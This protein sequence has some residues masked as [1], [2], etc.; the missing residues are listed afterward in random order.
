MEFTF[1]ERAVLDRF[2]TDSS[3]APRFAQVGALGLDERARTAAVLS[4]IRKGVLA[5]LGRNGEY[6]L[7]D[8]GVQLLGA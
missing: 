8:Q 1:Q 6:W 4:L 2:R 5:R 7:T 3:P